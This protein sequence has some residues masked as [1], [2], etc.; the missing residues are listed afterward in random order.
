[1][2]ESS[3]WLCKSNSMNDHLVYVIICIE[4][5]TVL[6]ENKGSNGAVCNSLISALLKQNEGWN[7][8]GRRLARRV[9]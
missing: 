1:M 7:D 8:A 4:D 2:E 6:V 9:R 5:N 3:E